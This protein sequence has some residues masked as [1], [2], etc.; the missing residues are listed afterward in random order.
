MN[1]HDYQN[2]QFLLNASR[3]TIQEWYQTVTED[4]LAY[5]T[6]LLLIATLEIDDHAVEQMDSFPEARALLDKIQNGK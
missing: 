5:A 1:N 3:E 6:E 2:L 4:E